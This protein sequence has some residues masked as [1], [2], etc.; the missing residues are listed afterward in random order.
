MTA[1]QIRGFELHPQPDLLAAMEMFALCNA[2]Y[3]SGCEW[4]SVCVFVCV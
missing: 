1:G 4:V 2:C 3:G